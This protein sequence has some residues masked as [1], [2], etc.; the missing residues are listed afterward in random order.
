MFASPGNMQAHK[1]TRV[2]N[3][4]AITSRIYRK[5]NILHIYMHHI[6]CEAQNI[7]SCRGRKTNCIGYIE[8]EALCNRTKNDNFLHTVDNLINLMCSRCYKMKL[9]PVLST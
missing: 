1:C 5:F 3:K 6:R 2:E 9:C 7:Y 8:L 4:K